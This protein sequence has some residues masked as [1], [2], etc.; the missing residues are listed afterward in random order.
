MYRIYNNPKWE[1]FNTRIHP[2]IDSYDEEKA[3]KVMRKSNR[4][5][6]FERDE[7][8][9]TDREIRDFLEKTTEEELEESRPKTITEELIDQA[10][11]EAQYIKK[12]VENNELKSN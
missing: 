5:K 4:Y 7:V 3:E 6:Y 2:A 10:L 11:Y 1:E 12:G 9:S 8:V